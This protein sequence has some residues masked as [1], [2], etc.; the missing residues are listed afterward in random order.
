MLQD[1]PN[2]HVQNRRNQSVSEGLMPLK[3]VGCALRWPRQPDRIIAAG[4]L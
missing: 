4:L 3:G 2:P 1:L